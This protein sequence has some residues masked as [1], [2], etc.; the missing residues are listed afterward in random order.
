MS[1]PFFAPKGVAVI[2]ASQD[3]HKLGHGVLRNLIQYRYKGGIYP[4]NRK[5]YE[6]LD[7]TCYPSVGEVPDPVDLAIIVVPA[8]AVADALSE[9]GERGIGHA[10]IVT[11][12]FSETGSE[13]KELEDELLKIA[14]SHEMRIIG[15]NCIGTIDT[16]TPVNTTF[17]VGMP[18]PG[19]IG[20]ISHSGAMVAA[21]IDWA[22]GS[23]IGFSRIVSLG[24]Q[25][26][27]NETDMMRTIADD[28]NTKVIT[29]YIEGVADGMKFL[30]QAK[31]TAKEKP[32]L[33]L[34]G[35]KGKS[36]AKAV[37]SHTGALAGST[38][39]FRTAFR[40][41]GIQEAE[42]IEEM[43]EWARAMAWQPLPKGN[44]VAVLTNA[45]GPAILAVDAL[46]KYGLQIASLSED[47][48]AFL[49][50]RL[51]KAASINNPVDV[52][53][54]SGPGTYTLALEALLS[55]DNIDAVV[56]IQAPQDWFLPVSLAEVVG[57]VAGSHD[58]TVITSIMGKASVEEALKI[59]QKRRIPNVAFPERSAS[60]L[61]AMIERRNWLMNSENESGSSL[62][63]DKIKANKAVKDRNWEEL[64]ELYGIEFPKQFDANTME[65][66]VE[67]FGQIDGPVAIKLVS[68][69]IS[70]KSDIGGV[71]LNVSSEDEVRSA[72]DKIE[73]AVKE[74]NGTMNGVI[75]QEMI[76]DAPEVITGFV[77]DDQFGPMVLFGSGG[78]DVELYKD[79][80]MA[81]A[82]LSET[83]A[84]DLIKRTLIY[85]K[86]T[87][88]RQYPEGDIESV[89]KVLTALG[90][91]AADHP[92]I[93]ELEIN[94]LSVLSKS[95]GSKA[96]DVRGSLVDKK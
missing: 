85:K 41:S 94:P 60:V 57:E 79:V 16:H 59:L 81:I 50:K 65:E 8:K 92:N 33:M 45:G 95:M 30:E 87:G 62:N 66:A 48:K 43:F 39:A 27:V 89:I 71:V 40:H 32:F 18:E 58:K 37:A 83:A 28:P 93:K 76:Q 19:E 38:E 15:P 63:I 51:P 23:G 68:D 72:W 46:E 55:D 96:L 21:I 5:A 64:L 91:I 82:P 17:V 13:G 90:Q 3:A 4:V 88:W 36:G 49:K 78:T 22:S 35:G 69:D 53:A 6:I 25:I 7:M 9:C 11:G 42:T 61:S 84:M 20:F 10:V 47:T 29:G 52:L 56:V 24:N 74:N 80:D 26:D 75:V 1:D 34:K 77:R 12:G 67:Y 14:D 73:S 31:Q 44:R 54:G 86:L 2:G 70:H